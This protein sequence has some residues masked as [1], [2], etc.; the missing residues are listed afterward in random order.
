MLTSS[1]KATQ[2]QIESVVTSNNQRFL[3]HLFPLSICRACWKILSLD[4]IAV[5]RAT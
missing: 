4:Q 1:T 5:H 2:K 3:L